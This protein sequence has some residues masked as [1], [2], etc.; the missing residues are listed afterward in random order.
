MREVANHGDTAAQRSHIEQL[1]RD[2]VDGISDDWGKNIKIIELME[3]EG[4]GVSSTRIR[5]AVEAKDDVVLNRYLT[6]EVCEEI[7]KSKMYTAEEMDIAFPYLSREH[8]MNCSFSFWHARFR[9][10]S[11]RA[12]I[13][14]PLP[15]SF[16]Q[17]LN[18]DGLMLPQDSRTVGKLEELSSDSGSEFEDEGFS[19]E[20]PTESFQELHER[21]RKEMEAL[22][23]AVVP[24]LNWSSP[25]DALWI[26]ADKTLKCTSPSD[27]YLLLK[28][29]DFIVHDLEEPF[30]ACNG[31]PMPMK[32]DE[33]ELVLK[34]WFNAQPSME[35][36]CFVKD[37]HLVAVSQRD[38]NYYDFLTSTTS[39]VAS[40]AAR[41]LEEHLKHGFPDPN[42]VFDIYASVDQNKAWLMDINPF[43]PATD[44]LLFEWA[45]ILAMVADT[46]PEIRLVSKDSVMSQG[47]QYSTN[48]VPYD[49]IDSSDGVDPAE[50]AREFQQRLS[51]VVLED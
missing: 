45:E 22:G 9:H 29:S 8:V 33:Y 23:G 15:V 19:E 5:E 37:S 17:Y 50:F 3:N 48:T 44:A 20:D 14:R 32:A 49:L 34:K 2:T 46:A 43:S 1:N 12:R 40:L 25:K 28:S 13:I 30:K 38:I 6:P 18:E 39:D 31:E 7:K 35:F 41:M 11:P 4:L 27:I 21:I 24:K 26:T 51:K 36:R 42:F 10:I 16:L 47:P